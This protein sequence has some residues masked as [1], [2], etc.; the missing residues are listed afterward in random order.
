MDL[1]G[2]WLRLYPV[3]F[4][5]L[6]EGKRFRRWDRVKF[7]WRRPSNDP[8][9]ESRHVNSQTLEIIGSV[10]KSERPN[11]LNKQIVYSLRREQEA[12]RSLALLKPE[13]I[14]F[15]IVKKSSETLAEQQRAIDLFHSQEDMFIPRPAVPVKACPFAFKYRYRTED[16]VREG[17]CQD[18]E[19]EATFFHWRNRY[20][21][22][23][24]L[25][26]MEDQFGS[27]LPQRGLYFAMGTHSLYPETWLINGLVQLDPPEQG[28]LF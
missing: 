10:P 8:R 7:A 11:L 26:R 5:V 17:T 18:W 4:R 6:E 28:T 19:T 14:G 25:E 24:A 23:G 21:E 22:K 1:Y 16:G 13:I 9:I 2:N 27:R 3:S 12:G 15:K 20:G